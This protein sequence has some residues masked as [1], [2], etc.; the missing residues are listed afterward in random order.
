MEVIHE[1]LEVKQQ[2]K[3]PIMYNIQSIRHLYIKLEVRKHE[4]CMI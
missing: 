3:Q 1:T 2:Q 4:E